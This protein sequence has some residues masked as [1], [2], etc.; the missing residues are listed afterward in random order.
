[1]KEVKE[2]TKEEFRKMQ[3][4]QTDMLVEFDRV[5]KAHGIKY[6]IAGGTML[7]AVR[8]K[9]YI[10]WDDDADVAMLR[11][12]YEKFKKVAGELDPELCYFQD[13]ETDPYY[14][15]GYGKLRRTG[16]TYVRVGQEHIKCKTGVFVD[17]FPLDDVPCCIIGQI[18]Q[19][20]Y[21]F[22]LRKILYSEVGKYSPSENVFTRAIY[23]LMS[24][25]P[26]KEVFKR[27]EK[28]ASKSR[29]ENKC[30]C[31]T[32]LFPS[33]GKM[34]KHKLNEKFSTPK[35]WFFET[36]EY[37]FEGHMLSGVKDYDRYLSFE[38]G[39][40]MQLPPEDQRQVHAPV[41]EYKF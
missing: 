34:R 13:H 14:R 37:E 31:R 5:C 35:E 19:D 40:Y 7:G 36:A 15:W 29:N 8:H 21:C 41:C 26:V 33:I 32:L 27:V 24:L 11:E 23:K 16:T 4:L 22:V 2:L 1:M 38:Y 30:G 10:P 9:G 25:I 18:W 3:L 28:M 12:E 17:V 20:F 6:V 39:D